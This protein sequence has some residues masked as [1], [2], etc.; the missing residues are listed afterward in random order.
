MASLSFFL[1]IGCV[2]PKPLSNSASDNS[3]RTLPL[4]TFSAQRE[5]YCGMPRATSSH[6]MIWDD[7]QRSMGI[8]EASRKRR[9]FSAYP[10]SVRGL[11]WNSGASVSFDVLFL[12]RLRVR[13][14]TLDMLP[15]V[16]PRPV[17]LR[18]VPNLLGNLLI[19]GGPSVSTGEPNCSTE[20]DRAPLSTDFENAPVF[21]GDNVGLRSFG[22]PSAI[23]ASD[24]W[25]FT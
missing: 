1:C 24:K 17:R 7:R 6:A 22:V 19:I 2:V 10:S 3:R 9:I 8:E 14:N 16:P 20:R 18:A 12:L 23:Y 13:A 4:F 25:T 15:Q 21:R 11:H 5:L